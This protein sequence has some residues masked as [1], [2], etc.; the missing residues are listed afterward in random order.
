MA[1]AGFPAQVWDAEPFALRDLPGQRNAAKG[2]V[3]SSS[4]G[5]LPPPAAS[6]DRSLLMS[7]A[8]GRERRKSNWFIRQPGPRLGRR[9]RRRKKLMAERSLLDLMNVRPPP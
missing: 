2:P 9:R 7:A 6:G 5:P 3:C 4:W 1:E 8:R